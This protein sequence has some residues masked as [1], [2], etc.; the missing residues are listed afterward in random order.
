M[1]GTTTASEAYLAR[2]CQQAFLHLWSYPNL[3]RDQGKESSAGHG[4]ELCDLLV[5]F[6]DNVFVFSD[7]HC[8]LQKNQDIQVAWKR[9]YKDA[10]V[11]SAAQIVGAERWLKQH[12]DRIF[13]DRACK[14]PFPIRLPNSPKFYR[15]LTCRGAAEASQRTWGGRGSLMVTNCSFDGCFDRPLH[16]GAFDKAGHFFHVF[17]EVA[18]DAILRTL[19]TVSDFCNYLAKRESFF[20]KELELLAAGE[21]ELLGFY[22]YSDSKDGSGHDFIV[23]G[24]TDGILIDESF[25]SSWL[26]GPQRQAKAEA[27]RVSYSWDRLIEKFSFHMLGGTQYFP[28]EGGVREDEIIV[29]WMARESRV[30]RRLLSESLLDAMN[31]TAQGQ[32]RRRYLLPGDSGDPFWVFLIFPRPDEVAYEKYR[33]MRFNYLIWHCEVV[34]YLHPEALDIVGIAVDPRP[35]EISEDGVYMD[36]RTWTEEQNAVAKRLH[37][38]GGI[39]RN[40]RQFGGRYWEYPINVKS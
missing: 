8:E 27:D 38:E 15:I 26:T 36:A 20:C 21:E 7:K 10:I 14:K 30:R 22:L 5:V 29:R 16:L 19:D 11:K 39:F 4:K 2:L 40:A 3:Y 17:D 9:W 12:P 6:G 28:S 13:L 32:M 23:E 33:D 37:E 25:W 1:E 34:K 31:T 24:D 35:E 18:L